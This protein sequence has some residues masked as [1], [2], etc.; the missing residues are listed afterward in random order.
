MDI[1]AQHAATMMAAAARAVVESWRRGTDE[2]ALLA[3][4][5]EVVDAES[6][7]LFFT[8]LFAGARGQA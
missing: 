7:K 5:A 2:K 3:H 4:L 8:H 6:G 1:E